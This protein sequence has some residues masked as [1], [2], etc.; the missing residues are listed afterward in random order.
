MDCQYLTVEQI[1]FLH[2]EIVK[3]T[4][5]SLGVRD[6]D[7]LHS[8][9]M[10]PQAS[11]CGQDL[12]SDTFAKAAALCQ[13]LIN[14]HPFVDGNKRIGCSACLLF[15]DIN[16]VSIE[17]SNQDFIKFSL[18]I[19]TKKQTIKQI[20]SWLKAKTIFALDKKTSIR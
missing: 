19:A 18:K 3:K 12:Y 9:A 7:L 2:D 11:F 20:S 14:N 1:V 13:S 6:W 15:L 10:R 4:G 5:G 8:A 16:K 17:I